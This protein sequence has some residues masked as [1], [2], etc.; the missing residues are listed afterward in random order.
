M[1]GIVLYS[2]SGGAINPGQDLADLA[3]RK[4]LPP[5]RDSLTVI[6]IHTATLSI[7]HSFTCTIVIMA[8]PGGHIGIPGGAAQQQQG[9]MSEQEMKMIKMVQSDATF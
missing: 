4:K 9:G 1:L 8:F 6:F 5:T 3:L 7:L 2:R